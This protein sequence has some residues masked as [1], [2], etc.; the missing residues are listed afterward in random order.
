MTNLVPLM[1]FGWIPVTVLSFFL[2]K[3]HQA[4]LFSVIGG[5]LF[6]PMAVYDL[7]GLPAYSK[8]TAISVG[9]VLGGRISGQRQVVTFTW[10][11]YDLPVIIY[12]ISSI[13]IS[14]SNHL[15]FYDGLA[16]F[17][18]RAIWLGIPYLAG[19]VYFNSSDKLRDLCKGI[20][21]GGLLYVPF[22]LYE[23]RMSPQ[24]H[25]M[26][27]GYFQH[28]FIQHA[29]YGGWR[30]IVFM[31]HGIMVAFWMAVAS[32][33]AFWSWRSGEIKNLKGVPMSFCVVVLSVTTIFCKSANGWF[34][35]IVGCV[36]YIFSRILKIQNILLIFFLIIFLYIGLR[37]INI[38]SSEELITL[39]SFVFDPERVSSLGM[40]LSQEDLFSLKAWERP[41]FGWGGHDRGLPVDLATGQ[42]IVSVVDSLW[43]ITFSSS[44]LVGLFS[45]Y[46]SL[47][48]GPFLLFKS[49]ML[50]K[51]KDS[52]FTMT[53]ATVLSL[54]LILFTI[55]SLLNAMVN[56]L[57]FMITGGLA[58]YYEQKKRKI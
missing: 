47:L 41:L 16:G 27:Y 38:V 34:A 26:I 31:Q 30:P 14:L 58:S 32:V 40:R 53:P 49:G 57:Y 1:L 29:R 37:S 10:K 52:S 23:M 51:V 5:W 3:P 15:G 24:L 43:L 28:S 46:F 7:Q 13:A 39:A 35:L 48:I 12:C 56:P 54:I 36:C 18:S 9:L 8:V 11:L 55:D 42:I 2:F 4:V 25:N 50:A 45:L 6:L 33:V 19:R 17:L 44:G 20:I 22:C 21:L